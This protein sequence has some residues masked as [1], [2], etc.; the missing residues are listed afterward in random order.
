MNKTRVAVL[1]G[2]ASNER[3]IS[4]ESGRN[5]VYKLSAEKYDVVPVFVNRAL[6]PYQL[7]H[8]HLVHNSTKEIEDSLRDTPAFAWSRLP[9]IADFVFI[10]LHGGVGENGCIQGMLEMLS[11]PYNGSGVFTTALCIDKHKT[12][13]FLRE[14]GFDVPRS[15]LIDKNEWLLNQQGVIE[16]ISQRLGLPVIVK[17]HDDGCSVLVQRATTSDQLTAALTTLFEQ[18]GKALVEEC[19]TGME[20]TVGVVGNRSI[21]ALPPSQAVATKGILSIEEKFLPGAG[22]NQTPAPLPLASL[23]FVQTT[24]EG[25]YRALGCQGYA[26]IDCFYQSA[27]QSPTGTERLVHLETNSLPGLTPATVIFHQAAEVGVSPSDFLDMIVELGLE[28]HYQQHP[29]QARVIRVEEKI[30]HKVRS[31][32]EAVL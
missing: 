12:N 2:G 4:L 31:A 26:R 29:Q 28:A 3:E 13:Q 19:V 9:Q 5:V 27:T 21:Y 30:L 18:K 16:S 6:V 17:P 23:S 20:L 22:E 8:K 7:S 11:L 1:F 32:R 10:A 25:M 15:I 24:I 14:K